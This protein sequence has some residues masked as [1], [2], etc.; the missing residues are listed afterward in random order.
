[1]LALTIGCAAGAQ[2]QAS[3]DAGNDTDVGMEARAALSDA[4]DASEAPADV[5]V[6]RHTMDTGSVD[7]GLFACGALTCGADEYCVPE[8]F[9]TCSSFDGGSCPTG[10]TP[11]ELAGGQMGCRA[12]CYSQRCSKTIPFGCHVSNIPAPR[13]LYCTCE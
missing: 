3:N 7:G 8:V 9:G 11:C 5:A 12:P 1:L 6:E 13:W 2:G 4:A 10:R